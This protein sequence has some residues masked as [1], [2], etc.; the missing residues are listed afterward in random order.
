MFDSKGCC[1]DVKK[2]CCCEYLFV[3]SCNFVSLLLIMKL[4]A[5]NALLGLALVRG[6]ILLPDTSFYDVSG[7]NQI[8][9]EFRA[10]GPSLGTMIL[11]MASGDQSSRAIA[12]EVE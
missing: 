4:H 3:S 12:G 8:W 11:A 2:E 9:S 10:S 6:N 7:L 5:L 1:C